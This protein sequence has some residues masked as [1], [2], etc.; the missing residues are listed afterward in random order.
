MADYEWDRM[1]DQKLYNPYKVGDTS[2]ERVHAAQKK[3]NESD[4]T[5]TVVFATASDS[6]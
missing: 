5:I 2:F 4:L 3:F 1:I 6:L